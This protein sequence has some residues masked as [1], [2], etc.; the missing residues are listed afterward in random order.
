MIEEVQKAIEDMEARG[1]NP[2]VRAVRTAIGGGS[3]T[4]VGEAIR[5]VNKKRDLL[6][7]VRNEL[8]QALQEKASILSLDFWLAAQELA[9]R[10]VEDVRRGCEMRVANAEGQ[11]NESLREIDDAEARIRELVEKLKEK[12]TAYAGLENSKQTATQRAEEAE[13]RVGKL[14]A[15]IRARDD[16]ATRRD[17]ELELAYSSINRMAAAMGGTNKAQPADTTKAEPAGTAKVAKEKAAPPATAMPASSPST[18]AKPAEVGDLGNLVMEVMKKAPEK[19]LSTAEIHAQLPDREN[20]QQR[21][22]YNLLYRR[23]AAGATFV[24]VGEGKFT[25]RD[26]GATGGGGEQTIR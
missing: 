9:N 1:I 21:Q 26:L 23:A 20:I 14:E 8:P 11:A 3:H 12:D 16:Y 24:S 15:E 25:L 19:A 22:V 13:A 18:N 5:K 6:N 17:R 4:D 2:S 10:V 7:T